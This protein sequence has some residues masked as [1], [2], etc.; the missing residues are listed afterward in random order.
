[1]SDPLGY[2]SAQQFNFPLLTQFSFGHNVVLRWLDQ[3]SSYIGM[4]K[5]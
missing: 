3:A 5:R 2:Q 1:M 4:Q